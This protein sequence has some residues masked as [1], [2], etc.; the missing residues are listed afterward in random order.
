[1]TELLKEL[2]TDEQVEMLK[3]NNV[4]EYYRLNFGDEDEY[5]DVMSN[6][7]T[8]V[9]F[10]DYIVEMNTLD[11]NIYTL[12]GVDDIF[13]REHLFERLANLLEWDYQDVYNIWTEY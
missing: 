6:I 12:I 2:L 8:D 4:S 5:E 1:M 3:Q 9:T 7:N 11:G 10:Y 13:V